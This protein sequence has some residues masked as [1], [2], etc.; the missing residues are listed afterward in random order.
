MFELSWTAS[1]IVQFGKDHLFNADY[2]E[3]R[4]EVDDV[5][6]KRMAKPLYVSV[7]P[8]AKYENLDT[9]TNL[10]RR[11]LEEKRDVVQ[12]T[13]TSPADKRE[14]EVRKRDLAPEVT[15]RRAS[16]ERWPGHH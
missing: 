11:I 2:S 3:C 6:Q 12:T 5:G 9:F 7:L 14:E 8:L 10:H 16:D 1:T 15:C 13:S 4:E